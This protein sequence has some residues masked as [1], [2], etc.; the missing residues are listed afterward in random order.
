MDIEA[1]RR[2]AKQHGYSAY[3]CKYEKHAGNVRG[4]DRS[5]HY[6]H[7]TRDGVCRSIGKLEVDV[8]MLSEEEVVA[9]I[10]SK[11]APPPVTETISGKEFMDILMGKRGES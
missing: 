3:L 4:D 7:V 8:A 10:E 11:F 6:V 5:G 9:R 2:L 1:I